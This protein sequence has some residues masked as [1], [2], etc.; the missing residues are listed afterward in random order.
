MQ[1]ENQTGTNIQPDHSK[2]TQQRTILKAGR[3]LIKISL[4]VHDNPKTEKNN[5]FRSFRVHQDLYI[6]I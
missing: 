1:S 4:Y 5:T 6:P 2:I 3:Q